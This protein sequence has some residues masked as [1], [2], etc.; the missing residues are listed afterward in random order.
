[1]LH[2][3][4]R[5]FVSS[6]AL[7]AVAG[8]R[9]PNAGPDAVIDIGRLGAKPQAADNYEAL[10]AAFDSAAAMNFPSFVLPSGTYRISKPLHIRHPLALNGCGAYDMNADRGG[11]V[12]AASGFSAPV[13]TIEPAADERLRGFCISGLLF[14]CARQSDGICIC[15]SADFSLTRVG[16]RAAAGF[17]MGFTNSWDGVIV[18]AFVSGCGKPNDATGA[19]DIV[20]EAFGGNTNSLHFFAARVESSRGPSLVIHPPLLHSGPNNNIQFVASKF[21]LPAGDGTTPPT[22]NL[23]LHPAEAI[24]F[25]GAQ[26]FDA[27]AGNPV[28]DF[29]S[30][31]AVDT[32]YAFFGCDIDVRAGDALIGGDLGPQHHFFGCTLRAD[33][34][35]SRQKVLYRGTSDRLG[36]IKELNHLYRLAA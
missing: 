25:H 6:G 35:A 17:G 29:R 5:A 1:M 22:P 33:P 12:I 36:Q 15:R 11:C 9:A 24:S 4:R 31:R 21:H 3:T 10:Q 16:V 28:I 8:V 34:A 2:A 32:A 7:A 20:G 13:L 18:D 30:S 19:I 27:G 26:I 14:D 23:I